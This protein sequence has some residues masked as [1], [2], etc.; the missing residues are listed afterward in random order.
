MRVPGVVLVLADCE[1]SSPNSLLALGAAALICAL[2]AAFVLM[3]QAAGE[4]SNDA[5]ATS[6]A[7]LLA[8]GLIATTPGLS[9]AGANYV[10]RFFIGLAVGAA[11][12]VGVAFVPRRNPILLGALGLLG[13][14][15]FLATGVLGLALAV[16][17][18]GDCPG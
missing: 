2:V 5:V 7:A 6:G 15:A 1:T 13:G 14:G 17:I 11:I 8:G 3:L 9:D 18:S 12:G 10:S 4:G 16:G